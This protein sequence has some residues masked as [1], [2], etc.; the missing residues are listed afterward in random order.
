MYWLNVSIT[1]T[2]S[3]VGLPLAIVLSQLPKPKFRPTFCFTSLPLTSLP[4]SLSSH[5][6]QSNKNLPKLVKVRLNFIE[7]IVQSAIKIISESKVSTEM[8]T[9]ESLGMDNLDRKA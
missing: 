7:K 3:N 4:I 5:E 8:S 2:V 6:K 9:K 1:S